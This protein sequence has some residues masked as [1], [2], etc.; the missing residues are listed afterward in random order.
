MK[1]EPSMVGRSLWAAS[2][3]ITVVAL[4]AFSTLAYSVYADVGSVGRSLSSSSS[5]SGYTTS[6][7]VNGTSETE[8]V[9]ATI[10]NAGLYPLVVGLSCLP[11]NGSVR[12]TCSNTEVTIPPG[13]EQTM[14]FAM[15]FQNISFTST[16]TVSVKGNVSLALVPFA[17]V[18]MVVPIISAS[19]RAG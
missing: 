5:P 15:V 9:N 14:H 2:V 16:N 3:V 8:Y 1:R 13:G 17:S 10:P 7:A 4:V 18:S 11:S 19:E 6:V 12:V